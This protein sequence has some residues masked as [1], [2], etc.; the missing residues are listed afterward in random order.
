[1][2]TARPATPADIPAV[3]ALAHALRAELQPM[4]GGALWGLRDA[5]DDPLD[6][7]FSGLLDRDDALV[8]VGCIDDAVVGFGTVVV[9]TLRDGSRL[10]VIGELFVDP[11]ARAVAVGE[12]VAGALVAFCEGAGCIGID[13]FA[14]PGHRE[15]KNFFERNGF[16]ARALTMF[17]ALPGHERLAGPGPTDGPAD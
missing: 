13:A 16:T 15:A 14:L 4:R 2:E 11:D 5:A 12:S 8:V 3:V 7:V 17:K 9:E 10:G 6:P 1:V